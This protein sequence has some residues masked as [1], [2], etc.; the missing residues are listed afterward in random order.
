MKKFLGQK[1]CLSCLIGISLLSAN[2]VYAV[3]YEVTVTNITQGQVFTPIL[4]FIHQAGF[5]P[6]TLGQ[7]AFSQVVAIAESGDTGPALETLASLPNFASGA[8]DTG[9]PLPP[10]KSVTLEFDAADGMTHISLLAMMIPTNDA[11]IGLNGV[12]L[13]INVGDT[14]VHRSV[15]YDA[16]SEL[17]DELCANIPGPEGVCSGEGVS[18]SDGEGYVH[19]HPGIHGIAD[20]AAAKYDW[21]NPVALISITR[22]DD[23]N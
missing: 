13:P 19:I 5:K 4:G 12:V 8:K 17:N 3:D 7:P 11:F 14:V 2:N 21:R 15:A 1:L 20:L 22:I 16:G 9:A 10:G 23:D 18:D 6:I